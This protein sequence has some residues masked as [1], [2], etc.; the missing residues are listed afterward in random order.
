VTITLERH[1]DN[2][3]LIT[4]DYPLRDKELLKA[5]P[6]STYSVRA[7]EWTAP[8]TWGT[9]VAMRGMFGDELVVGPRL[10]EWSI[11]EHANRIAQAMTLRSSWD[12]PSLAD[13]YP[14]LYPFQRAGVSFLT[15]ARQALLTDEMGT[16]KT[17]QTIFTLKNHL[18]LGE[19]PFPALIVAPNNMVY[20]WK[21]EIER[22]WPEAKVNVI[23]GHIGQRRK[24][25]EDPAHFYVINLEGVRGHSK[26]AGYGSI[27]LR[28]CYQCNPMMPND[29]T[30]QP[31]RCETHPKELNQKEWKTLIIDEAHRMKDPA[32]KQSR[33]IKSLR[34]HGND[35]LVYGLTGTPI[36]D[37]PADLWTM[38]NLISPS[39]FPSRQ[40][41]IDRYCLSSYNMF[42]G[43]SVIGLNPEHKEE[44]FKIVEPRFR[45]MPKA[46]VL[47]FLPPKV[48]IDRF[49]E[50]T[51]PQAKAYKQ[52]DKNQIAVLES[53][54]GLEELAGVAVSANP[55]T[56][57]GRLTQFA[58]AYATVTEDGQIRLSEPSNK[59]DALMEILEDTGDEPA[60]VMAQSR[61]LIELAAARLQKH[62]IP[63]TKIVGGQGAWDREQAKERFQNGHVRVI[64]CTISAGG[65]GITLTR[66][67]RIIFLQRSWS[68][69]EQKQAEDR[70]HRIGSEIHE[71]IEIINLIAPGTIEEW[72]MKALEGKEERMQE[73][74]R[75]AEI[76]AQLNIHD[77][78]EELVAS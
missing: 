45:R 48:R 43:F 77:D 17:I 23:K 57:L 15:F 44:F 49:I 42:G 70:V 31:A 19:N 9:C 74:V 6:G 66:S 64:L 61:Q 4:S 47:P 62:K 20:T 34:R 37:A 1:G 22:W 28:Q 24:L 35:Q 7:H 56:E 25:I 46:A 52:M 53:P 60:V 38:L 36:G 68:M 30:H 18:R 29:K 63:F 72:Q 14:E 2:K 50:M 5:L 26:L 51:A 21:R 75:D 8:L 40:K 69:I 11:N 41:Y 58:S 16:G 10:T 59:I 33:A 32:A 27:R 71:N 65:I 39:E 13:I 54:D 73:F 55:L 3:V 78:M 67:K 12:D 76:V